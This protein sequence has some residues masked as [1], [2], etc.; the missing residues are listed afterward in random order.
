MRSFLNMK[1][2]QQQQQQQ[3]QQQNNKKNSDQRK[4]I[5]E[6]GYRKISWFVS[7]SYINY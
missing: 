5:I 2:K 1:Q 4:T 3:Q 7:V 6:H